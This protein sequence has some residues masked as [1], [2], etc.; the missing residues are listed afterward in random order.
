MNSMFIFGLLVVLMLTS[1]A[2]AL[3]GERSRP[4]APKAQKAV[5]PRALALARRPVGSHHRRMARLAFTS[6]LR[7]FSTS[8]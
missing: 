3:A 1:A 8:R 4:S 7:R 6:Q 2:P 5:A